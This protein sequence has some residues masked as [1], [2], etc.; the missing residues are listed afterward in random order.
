MNKSTSK[1]K[2]LRVIQ[3]NKYSRIVNIP[4]EY[5]NTLSINKHDILSCHLSNSKIILEKVEIE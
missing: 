2:L 5:C 1:D 4:A 3:R